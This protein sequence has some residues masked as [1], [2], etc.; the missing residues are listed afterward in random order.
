[1]HKMRRF[2]PVEDLEAKE[3]VIGFSE[4]IDWGLAL[5]DVESAWK[6]TK[7]QG[8]KI[9]VVDTGISDHVDLAG[10]IIAKYDATG[11]GVEPSTEHGTHVAG[12]ITANEDDNGIVGVAPQSQVYSVKVLASGGMGTFDYILKGLQICETLDCNIIN[13]SLGVASD[14]PAE[15]HNQ[16][17][18]L[19]HQNKIIIAAAGNDAGA[20]NYPAAYPEVIAVGAIDKTKTL[21]KF[22]SRGPEIKAVAPGVDI[23]STYGTNEYR[24]MSGTSMAAPFFSGICALLLSFSKNNP[25]KL[26]I[27]TFDDLLR[28]L[29]ILCDPEVD[30]PYAGVLSNVGFG[31]PHF[32]NN[33]PWKT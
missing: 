15:I 8:I 14:P 13:M 25:D 31:I 7:G 32:A 28:I 1:M 9:A 26:K 24:T 12:I 29:D 4:T 16:I 17:Q 33:M 11:E 20:V 23:L 27:D 30:H 22:A 10:K 5:T 6:S 18:K 2:I 19:Y 21:A 3:Q